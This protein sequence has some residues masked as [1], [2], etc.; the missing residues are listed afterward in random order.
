MTQFVAAFDDVIIR[1]YNMNR[2]VD[3]Q[4]HVRYVYAPK[5]RVLFD[6][7][8][9]AQNITIPVISVSIAS[10]SRANDRVFN[11]IPGFYFSKSSSDTAPASA[12]SGF[13]RTPVPIDITV[14]MSVITK[15]QT[16]MD[17]ILS[18][19]IPYANPYIIISW[20]IPSEFNLV[21]RY[22][23]R[24]EVLWSG[25]V[26]L[27][28]PVELPSTEKFR[29]VGDTS[30]TIKGW[31][32]PATPTSNV[33]NVFYIDANLYNSASVTLSSTYAS[34]SGSTYTYAPSALLTDDVETVSLSG[35][36]ITLQVSSTIT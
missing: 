7:T 15:Y 36:T 5:E 13:F 14:N 33:T 19:F 27:Q 9:K 24:S 16:D 1:R 22:E 25:S 32:F 3:S 26:N 31:L 34:L 21:N 11:K 8:N 18:N 28:Y 35:N 30:F 6:L 23:L 12:T 2:V 4:V 10:I 29:I 17:Q 20:K